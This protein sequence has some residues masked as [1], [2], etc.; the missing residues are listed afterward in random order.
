VNCA[1]I[2][3]RDSFDSIIEHQLVRLH[4]VDSDFEVRGTS[5]IRITDNHTTAAFD[6]S[7]GHG[8]ICAIT[9]RP[10]QIYL[11]LVP[12]PLSHLPSLRPPK[13]DR[14]EVT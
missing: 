14:L 2:V 5:S 4:A 13:V 3:L 12:V 1:G 8:A 11:Y 6:L 7:H 10:V 9:G